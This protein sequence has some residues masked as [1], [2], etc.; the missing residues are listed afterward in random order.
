MT[1]RSITF[2]RSSRSPGSAWTLVRRRRTSAIRFGGTANVLSGHVR[3][4]SPRKSASGI[5]SSCASW[6]HNV[7]LPNPL[8]FVLL[9]RMLRPHCQ[10]RER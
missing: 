5:I 4:N 9:K 10:K 2:M 1:E 6:I 8:L 3:T 7:T